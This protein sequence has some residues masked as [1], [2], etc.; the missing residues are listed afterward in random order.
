MASRPLWSG[1]E[2][3]VRL[4]RSDLVPKLCAWIPKPGKRQEELGI[5]RQGRRF[6]GT[7][8]PET[9]LIPL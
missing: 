8:K 6:P 9:S 2:A 3:W 4:A 7:L 1:G 5:E